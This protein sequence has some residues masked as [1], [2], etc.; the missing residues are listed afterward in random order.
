M[1]T[2]FAYLEE[3]FDTPCEGAHDPEVEATELCLS[4]VMDYCRQCLDDDRVCEPCHDQSL[5]KPERRL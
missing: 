4:C 2:S 5:V 3:Q 1:P